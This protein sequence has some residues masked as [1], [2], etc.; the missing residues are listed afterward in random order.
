MKPANENK[1]GFTLIELLVV[2][3]I[4]AIL[5]AMLL[6]ALAKAKLKAARVVCASNEKQML[7]ASMIYFDDYKAFY[8]YNGGDGLWMMESMPNQ[9]QVN[10]VRLCPLSDSNGV[11]AGYG[12]ADKAWG[13]GIPNSTAL[14]YGG[15]TLNGHMYADY[16]PTGKSFGKPTSV[17]NPSQAPVFGD[18]MWVDGWVAPNSQHTTDL[19]Q[20][21]NPSPFGSGY[22]RYEVGRHGSFA[23][24][25]SPRNITGVPQVGAINLALLDGHVELVKLKNLLNFYWYPNWPN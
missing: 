2:I 1:I 19:Y 6:P 15:Y 11:A 7:L 10:G 4:I 13:Y 14:F 3:A 8:A 20:Q 22:A 12:A 21:P 16:D 5:A 25:Q 24:K 18:G 23:P 9:M 17:M